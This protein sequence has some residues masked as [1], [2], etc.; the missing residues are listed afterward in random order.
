MKYLPFLLVLLMVGI[1]CGKVFYD[2]NILLEPNGK[3]CITKVEI[4]TTVKIKELNASLD[5]IY[6][7]LPSPSAFIYNC[8]DNKGKMDPVIYHMGNFTVL[9]LL[10]NKYPRYPLTFGDTRK[11]HIM[12]RT[13]DLVSLGEENV[14]FY[15][16]FKAFGYSIDNL[17]ITVR[18]PDWAGI[19]D[20]YPEPNKVIWNE[21]YTDLIYETKL[22]RGELFPTKKDLMVVFRKP[23]NVKLE[24]NRTIFPKNPRKDKLIYVH[25]EINNVGN[26]SAFVYAQDNYPPD[27]LE[28]VRGKIA[29]SG[30]LKSKQKKY[31]FYY[32]KASKN[33]TYSLKPATITYWDE[34]GLKHTLKT[35]YLNFTVGSFKEVETKEKPLEKKTIPKVKETKKPETPEKEPS[36]AVIRWLRSLINVFKQ[37]IT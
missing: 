12:Y 9:K 15:T 28:V 32:I 3:T 1:T 14:L 21:S 36:S 16:R 17:K 33:G 19:Y 23:T 26:G 24:F 5:F 13:P 20:L 35:S 31:F 7:T 2:Y 8:S 22:D 18:L 10:Y 25:F 29:W 30:F 34:K 37:L 6:L 11:I 27:N 4:N